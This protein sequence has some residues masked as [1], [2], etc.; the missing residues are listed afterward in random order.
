MLVMMPV[1]VRPPECAA[2]H[3]RAAP[4]RQEK[5]ADTGRA[6]GLVRKVAVINAGHG[7][8]PQHIERNRRPDGESTRPHPDHAET[9]GVQD[10]ERD[11]PHPVDLV[12]L[13]PHLFRPLRRVVGIN[14]LYDGGGGAAEGRGGT[15]L[16][17]GHETIFRSAQATAPGSI[18]QVEFRINAAHKLFTSQ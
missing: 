12:R 10:D 5:L 9:A 2:L 11:T 1:M 6:V 8:H 15:D 14:P 7:K 17:G 18:A 13:V 3:G 4:E 16:I